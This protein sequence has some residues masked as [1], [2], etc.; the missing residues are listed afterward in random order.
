VAHKDG[1]VSDARTDAGILY[2]PG[3]AVVV[4]VLTAGNADRR[5]A[6]DNAGDLLCA[7][8]ARAVYDHC[9]RRR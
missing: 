3:G 5:W 8:V 9:T 1:S 4:V 7:R 6:S 2:T